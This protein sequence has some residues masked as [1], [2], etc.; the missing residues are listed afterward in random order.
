MKMIS[1]ALEKRVLSYDKQ[2]ALFSSIVAFVA[3]I[4]ALF[5]E[6]GEA[7]SL[8]L[9]SLSLSLSP[10]RALSFR[11]KKPFERRRRKEGGG[12]STAPFGKEFRRYARLRLDLQSRLLLLVFS[13]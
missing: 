8:F 13:L 9:V 5:V 11:E 3:R 1:H 6:R 12:A 2:R 7:L 10:S 4:G